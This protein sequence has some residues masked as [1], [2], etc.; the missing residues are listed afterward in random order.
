[1]LKFV[2]TKCE[3]KMA[4]DDFEKTAMFEKPCVIIEAN[5]NYS[6]TYNSLDVCD[7][8]CVRIKCQQFTSFPKAI[9]DTKMIYFIELESH[10]DNSKWLSQ[11]GYVQNNKLLFLSKTHMINYFFLD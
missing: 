4:I 7:Y 5:D 2:T 8:L 6:G 3:L 1:M 10:M 9:M 11:Y